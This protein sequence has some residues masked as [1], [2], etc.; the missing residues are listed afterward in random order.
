MQ[1]RCAS[2]FPEATMAALAPL[3]LTCCKNACASKCS[4]WSATN[5]SPTSTLRLSVCTRS[6]HTDA[7]PIVRAPSIHLAASPKRRCISDMHAPIAYRLLCERLV[8][9]RKLYTVYFLVC[10]VS[11]ASNQDQIVWVRLL[12]SFC[13]SLRSIDNFAC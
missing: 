1:A 6:I 13:N 11:F 8:A 3:W 2:A 5:R 9:K 10:F 12:D 4:P 7:S